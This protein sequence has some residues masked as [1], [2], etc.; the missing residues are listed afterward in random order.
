MKR[1]LLVLVVAGA[2]LLAGCS[3]LT[4]SETPAATDE[5]ETEDS[6]AASV[7][8]SATL[9]AEA[10]AGVGYAVTVDAVNGGD[11]AGNHTV[12][13]TVDGEQVASETVRVDANAERSVT[14]R[15]IFP[16]P[17]EYTVEVAGE[18]T[19]VTAIENPL[20]RARERMDGVDTIV[21]EERQS[22]N[23]T[24]QGQQNGRMIMRGEGTGRYDMVHN[25]SYTSMENDIEFGG[26]SFVQQVDTWYANGTEYERSKNENEMEYEY[27]TEETTFNDVTPPTEIPLE[28]TNR[29]RATVTD[30]TVI[31]R[32]NLD[33]LLG[34]ASIFGN[35]S[36][37]PGENALDK[38]ESMRF[39]IGVDRET[40]Y[41]SYVEMDMQIEGLEIS[42]ST[43]SG[44]FTMYAEFVE[45]DTPVDTALPESVREGASGT[46]TATSSSATASAGLRGQS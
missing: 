3:G 8:A 1:S 21:T 13:L 5:N 39:E 6:A 32:G 44:N 16:G 11:T 19:T 12:G 14:L 10:L 28:L 25:Q 46:G 9:D 38:F 20:P 41:I 15:H 17:G 26:F 27:E 29:S 36:S 37:G 24:L 42:G 31:V 23:L 34:L 45:F 7:E 2:V 4:G 33:S 35:S 43:G 18:S 40:N 22:M 30:D